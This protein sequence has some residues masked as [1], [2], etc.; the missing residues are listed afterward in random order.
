MNDGD[1]KKI[2]VFQNRCL[3]RII[4]IKGQD[5]VS[6]RELLER[7]NVEKLSEEAIHWTHPQ[8]TTWQ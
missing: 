5:K 8:T 1:V 2:D 3:R 4:K 7:V 6:I